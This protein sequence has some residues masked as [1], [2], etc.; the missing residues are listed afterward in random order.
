MVL[1]PLLTA[2]VLRAVWST[3]VPKLTIGLTAIVGIAPILASIFA[4]FFTSFL[5]TLISTHIVPL[6]PTIILAH[7]FRHFRV[8][9]HIF[10]GL[11]MILHPFLHTTTVL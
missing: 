9:P 8:V 7:A 10:S 1:H 3:L 4:P 11:R 2:P 5:S 6:I